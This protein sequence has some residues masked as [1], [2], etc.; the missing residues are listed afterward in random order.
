VEFNA[1]VGE[2]TRLVA[3]EWMNAERALAFLDQA[4]TRE[5]GTHGD[6]FVRRLA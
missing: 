1:L 6:V 5:R 4:A 2:S 3:K